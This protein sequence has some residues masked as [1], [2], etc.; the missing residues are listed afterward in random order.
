[1]DNSKKVIDNGIDTED[2][3]KTEEE[4]K[5]SDYIKQKLGKRKRKKDSTEQTSSSDNQNRVK[6]SS[7]SITDFFDRG[8]KKKTKHSTDF[9]D[10]SDNKRTKH[11]ILNHNNITQ[12]LIKDYEKEKNTQSLI[13]EIKK[14]KNPDLKIDSSLNSNSIE[15]EIENSFLSSENEEEKDNESE[16]SS[17][18]NEFEDIKNKMNELVPN[19]IDEINKNLDTQKALMNDD[20]KLEITLTDQNTNNTRKKKT[21]NKY[22]TIDID[23]DEDD[24]ISNL[25]TFKKIHITFYGYK[26]VANRFVRIMPI[27]L[28]VPETAKFKTIFKAYCTG[29]KLKEEDMLFN[30][31]NIKI[32]STSTLKGLYM[33][34]SLEN[35][36]IDVFYKNEY[37]KYKE[38]LESQR[39]MNEAEQQKEKEKQA[40]SNTLQNPLLFNDDDDD[41]SSDRHINIIIQEKN[42]KEV[43]VLIHNNATVQDLGI[44]Y[45]NK[46]SLDHSLLSR[47]CFYFDGQK[48]DHSQSLRE[49]DI[50]NQDIVDLKISN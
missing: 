13:K 24:D 22:T 5:L 7:D 15:D 29:T 47:L 3:K 2:T 12:N 39:M 18:N 42:K 34:S 33:T 10:R 20:N 46:L 38:Q 23:E 9:F 8:D 17:D 31:N 49:V 32:Y 21:S 43:K 14:E 27:T 4:Q 30:Y 25:D 41:F 37:P 36:R 28:E 19:L 40:Q 50:D 35:Y 16:K 44:A 26:L 48:L 1:M 6:K 11:N 45:L